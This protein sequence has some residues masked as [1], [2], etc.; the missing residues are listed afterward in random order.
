[1]RIKTIYYE[2]IFKVVKNSFDFC[3]ILFSY[4]L[5]VFSFSKINQ[6]SFVLV[7]CFLICSQFIVIMNSVDS[8][9]PA[10]NA[11]KELLFPIRFL[12]WLKLAFVSLFGGRRSGGSFENFSKSSNNSFK[13]PNLNSFLAQYGLVIGLLAFIIVLIGL[14]FGYIGSV[15]SFV[16]VEDLVEKKSNILEPFRK[17]IGFGFNYFLF[18]L[19]LGLVSLITLLLFLL[20]ALIPFLTGMNPIISIGFLIF[21]FVVWFLTI[22]L[23]LGLISSFTHDFILPLMYL[24]QQGLMQS[25]SELKKLILKEWKEFLVYLIVSFVLSLVGGVIALILL[26]PLII[27]GVVIAFI[28]AIIGFWGIVTSGNWLLIAVIIFLAIPLVF[29]FIYLTAIITLPINVFFRYYSII[30]LGKT[31]VSIKKILNIKKIKIN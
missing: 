21:L 1:M 5:I 10:F 7:Y 2:L 16:F 15:F 18:N 8:V 22:G 27:V 4:C 20:P 3:K 26:I 24:K 14:V 6:T 31:S 30:F 9:E 11:M 29:L 23:I 17:N 28:L 25:W 12:F 13:T 19:F